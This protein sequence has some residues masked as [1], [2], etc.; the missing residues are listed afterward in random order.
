MSNKLLS[1]LKSFGTDV[2]IA[3]SVEIKRPHL[4]EIGSHVAIDSHFYCTTQ[5]K[6]GSW[7]HVAPFVTIIGGADGC[8]IMGNFTTIAA[9]CRIVCASDSH[10]G[11]GLVSPVIPEK[12]RDR[13]IT[14]PVTMEDYSSL[15]SN[16]V[17]LPGVV[18]GEGAVVGANSFVNKNVP[19]WE[20][21][22]GS[23][24]KFLRKRPSETMKRYGEELLN[25]S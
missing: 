25:E 2:F 12:Y 15:A 20:I 3:E 5:L 23:P 18:I 7:I 17:V 16:V 21:W 10:L 8:L 1:S 4:V 14:S 13:V 9:G 22:A 11:E 6:M 24:A 19:P